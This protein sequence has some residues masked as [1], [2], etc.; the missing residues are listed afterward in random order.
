MLPLVCFG[1]PHGWLAC[2]AVSCTCGGASNM[3]ASVGN[4]VPLVW[5][6]EPQSGL[7]GLAVS[8]APCGG[9]SNMVARRA[10]AAFLARPPPPELRRE[11]L[12]A[13]TI[14]IEWIHIWANMTELKHSLA[15]KRV[16][17][18]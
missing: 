4:V 6:G 9:A 3:E 11:D 7:A 18:E 14:V 8:S 5:L 10:M 17:E 1:E 12:H 13:T 16:E 2:L 15:A